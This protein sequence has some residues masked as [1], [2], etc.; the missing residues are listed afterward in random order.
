MADRLG[1]FAYLSLNIKI[2][3]VIFIDKM[4]FFSR[5]KVKNESDN[6]SI[7]FLALSVFFLVKRHSDGVNATL[8]GGV[9]C[10]SRVKRVGGRL[11]EGGVYLRL[12]IY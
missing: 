7:L 8:E 1:S 5:L 6:C 4:K 2:L 11:L 9:C 10:H 12:G 3:L